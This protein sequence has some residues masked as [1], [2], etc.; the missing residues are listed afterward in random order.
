MDIQANLM[1][2]IITTIKIIFLL[3][4]GIIALIHYFQIKEA[5][6]MERKMSITL[7]AAVHFSMTV[8]LVVSLIFVFASTIYLFIF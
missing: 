4:G 6:K 8:Q 3:A 5:N 7:P 1:N 2:A